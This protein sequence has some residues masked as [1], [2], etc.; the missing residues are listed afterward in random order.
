MKKKMEK[1]EKKVNKNNKNTR[2]QRRRTALGY[3]NYD[4]MTGLIMKCKIR[5]VKMI[6]EIM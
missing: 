5:Y 4:V 2:E 3:C 6:M 1:M